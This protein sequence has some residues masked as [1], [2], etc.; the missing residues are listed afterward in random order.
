MFPLAVTV[1]RDGKSVTL[2]NYR[3]GE[4]S[5]NAVE[6]KA[7][8]EVINSLSY[9]GVNIEEL[10]LHPVLNRPA[11]QIQIEPFRRRGMV[12]LLTNMGDMWPSHFRLFQA[13][14]GNQACT[15]EGGTAYAFIRQLYHRFLR[16][17]PQVFPELERAP[18]ETLVSYDPIRQALT[19]KCP[20][21]A[22]I[23]IGKDGDHARQMRDV[24]ANGGVKLV[25]DS[26]RPVHVKLERVSQVAS[27]LVAAG[28]RVS[29]SRET[30]IGSGGLVY[31]A[32]DRNGVV[33]TACGAVNSSSVCSAVAWM[34]EEYVGVPA[35][36]ERFIMERLLSEI[37]SFSLTERLLSEAEAPISAAR[38]R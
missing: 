31:T 37:E 27:L 29:S 16:Y 22:G 18:R 3:D 11:T 25:I 26:K 7:R 35:L 32:W 13:I 17:Y 1:D 38:I 24:L 15:L 12:Y 20:R 5:R 36:R 2:L 4:R 33:P 23:L 28:C 19:V 10:E 30:S 34:I 21:Y 8:L 14:E 6:I 9:V